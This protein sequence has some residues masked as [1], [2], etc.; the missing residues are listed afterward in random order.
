MN[1][2]QACANEFSAPSGAAVAEIFEF[3]PLMISRIAFS[4]SFGVLSGN[5]SIR[6][7]SPAANIVTNSSLNICLPSESLP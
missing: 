1:D 4:R 7:T 2:D 6:L 5:A 3:K